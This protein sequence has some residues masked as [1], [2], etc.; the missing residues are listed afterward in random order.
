MKFRK[1]YIILSLVLAVL[2]LGCGKQQKVI[3]SKDYSEISEVDMSNKDIK[4]EELQNIL[5][6]LILN[7]E[8]LNKY[9]DIISTYRLESFPDIFH[10]NYSEN[11]LN[12]NNNFVTPNEEKINSF[13]SSYEEVE[14]KQYFQKNSKEIKNML[15]KKEK[16][17]NEEF[18]KKAEEFIDSIEE[19]LIIMDEIRNYYKN[20][21]YQKDNFEKGKTLSEKYVKSYKNSLEKYDKFFREFTKVKHIVT[22]NAISV[23]KYE[24]D[25]VMSYNKLKINLLCDMFRDKFYGSKLY[26]DTSKPFVIEDNDKEKYVNELKSIQKTLDHT[27]FDMRKLDVSKLSQE[28]ISNEEFKNMLQKLED[29]SKNTKAIITKIE[30]GKND[31]VN[32]M[33]NEYSEK[34]EKLK[35]E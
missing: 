7:P 15:S 1:K 3:N 6:P 21:E 8:L 22:K 11:F 12:E 17:K 23:L 19:K 28:N 35:K 30:T 10:N 26:I 33:I 29:I 9:G 25:K 32:E 4:A 14:Y 27:I 24:P 34:V 2:I 5:Y 31:E 13:L 18:D 20:K 16:Y